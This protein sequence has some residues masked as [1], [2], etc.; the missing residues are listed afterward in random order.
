MKIERGEDGKWPN[1][2]WPGMYQL[3][4][5]TKDGLTICPDCANRDVDQSQ[6]VIDGDAFFEGPDIP[7]DDCGKQIESSYGDPNISDRLSI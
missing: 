3:I 5:F 7:C 1:S 4:Y 6:E 2:A